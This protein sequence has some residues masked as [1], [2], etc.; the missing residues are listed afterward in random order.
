[1][2]RRSY[3]IAVAVFAA[4]AAFSSQSSAEPPLLQDTRPGGWTLLSERTARVDEP[5]MPRAVSPDGVSAELGWVKYVDLK[6]GNGLQL[7]LAQGWAVRADWDRQRPRM[8]QARETVDTLLLGLQ[9][10]FR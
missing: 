8:V 2:E 3:S 7:D 10:R 1:M 9:Y 5:S 6:P 4:L